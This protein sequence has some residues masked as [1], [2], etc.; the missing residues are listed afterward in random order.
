MICRPF[1]GDQK[2]NM[3]TVE[4]VWE[5]G[6]GV[7]GGV[8]TK[9]GAMMALELTLKHKEGNKMREKIMVLKN[10]ARQAAVS[11]GSSPRAFNNLV[12]IVTK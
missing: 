5:I 7:E 8:I 4:A 2:L 12:E 9:D 11:N 3:N 1:F 6:V 10:L